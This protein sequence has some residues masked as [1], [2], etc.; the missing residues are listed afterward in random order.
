MTHKIILDT[1]PG[2]DDSMAIFYAFQS[3]E[4]EVVGLTTIFG[5]VPV[6]LSAKNAVTLTKFAEQEIPVTKGAARPWTGPESTYSQHVHGDDGFGNIDFPPIEGKLDPRTSAQ[7]IVDMARKYPGEITLVAIGPLTNL[8]LAL[9]LEPELPK[10]I[11]G[12]SIMGGAAFVPGNVT[13]VAEANIWN[14]A[15]AAEIVFDAEWELTMFGLDVTYSVSF[16]PEWLES[17]ADKNEKL[18][19]FV[20]KA[21]QFYMDFYSQH[22]EDR[23]CFFHDAMP[24]AHL[25]DPTLYEF[26]EGYARVATDPLSYGN[27]MVAPENT[28]DCPDWLSA[29][30]IKVATKVDEQRLKELYVKTYSL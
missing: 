25:V 2:I 19:G 14:D 11:K 1:D 26:T 21:A 6:E 18:G 16:S 7:F 10:L 5:N 13:P 23:V 29:R 27:T 8:A 17:I 12:V 20:N 3:P 24:I 28:T 30:K 4:I 9:R 15:H 22:R